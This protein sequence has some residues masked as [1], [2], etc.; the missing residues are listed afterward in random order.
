M[1]RQISSGQS[2]TFQTEP[3]KSDYDAVIVGSGPNGLAA[4]IT[5]AREGHSVLVI[6]A[7][8][9]IGGG[10]R[11]QE[12]T[13]PGFIHDVCSAVHPLGVMSP[14]FQDLPLDQHGLEWIMPEAS[15]V[16]ALA[17]EMPVV[18][19]PSIE[20]TAEA[21]GD[22]GVT[23]SRLIKPFVSRGDE[24][25]SEI[26]SPF[27]L[28]PD[29]PILMARFGIH[30]FASA[31]QL[32]NR[33]FR[34]EK[35][36]ALFSGLAGHATLP[37]EKR[38][39]A[40]VGLMFA[41]IG[42]MKAW[43]IA[44]G[45]SGQIADAM[46]RY[47]VSL[48]G[49]LVV[50]KR[51]EHLEDLPRSRAILF[52]LI[53]RHLSDIVGDR[54]SPR[55]HKKLRSFRHGPASFKIDWALDGPVPWLHPGYEKAATVHI[56]GTISEIAEAERAP[57]EG[58]CAD[59]PFVLYSQQSL[60]D[61]SRA[62]DGKHTGWGYCHV[63]HG[64]AGDATDLI[65]SQIERFAPGFRDRIISRH[66]LNVRGMEQHNANYLGGDISGGVMDLPQILRRPLSVFSPYE[67]PSSNIFLCSSSTP[68]GPGVH[69]LCGYFAAKAALR[70]ALR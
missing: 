31:V 22:D 46:A 30:G 51:I 47:L 8:D 35:A 52:D 62:P 26:L 48:G 37:L 60:F 50:G 59:R 53:P 17:P 61:P 7:C 55:V 66:V 15:V 43:P 19:Y 56:G 39:T 24:L 6:E 33:L 63:P 9:T 20:K 67:T 40:A 64:Y 57:W 21:L 10:T 28:L 11:S 70:K 58:C 23:Y 34:E 2:L 4:A 54:F 5:L 27:S 42:H 45:G 25:L 12:L 65:E 49:E 13:E 18:L 38:F 68:P 3:C 16:H 36:A 32:C 41:V 69:G 14:F 44:R 29:S 1:L